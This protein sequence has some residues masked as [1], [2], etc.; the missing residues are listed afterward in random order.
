MSQYNI[1]YTFVLFRRMDPFGSN[2]DFKLEEQYHLQIIPS[3]RIMSTNEETDFYI[4]PEILDHLVSTCKGPNYLRTITTTTLGGHKIAK[5]LRFN[6]S[7]E[8]LSQN[9]TFNR[10]LRENDLE[11]ISQFK[12]LSKRIHTLTS[13]DPLHYLLMSML[14][15]T[16]YKGFPLCDNYER[17]KVVEEFQRLIKQPFIPIVMPLPLLDPLNGDDSRT[18]ANRIKN[19]A[20]NEFVKEAYGYQKFEAIDRRAALI[21]DLAK[22]LE[23]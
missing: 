13:E 11:F 17:K 16:A 9:F 4:K 7:P 5:N 19:V 14:E 18:R 21:S 3:F 23:I 8:T 6:E 10:A 15:T 1:I 12:Q 2:S 22:T 20:V